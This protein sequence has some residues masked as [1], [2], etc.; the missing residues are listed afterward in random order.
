M[1]LNPGV[2]ATNVADVH[3]MTQDMA[4][5]AERKRLLVFA[6]NRQDAA[7]QAGWMKD[8]ARRFR[9][10]ALTAEGLRSGPVSVGDLTLHLDDLLER[11]RRLNPR[12]T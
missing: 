1:A 10:R 9:L 4:H 3:V 7:F 6:D 11:D 5:H 12:I 2:R 8:H